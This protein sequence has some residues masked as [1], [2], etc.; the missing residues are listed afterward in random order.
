MGLFSSA[1]SVT[2]AGLHLRPPPPRRPSRS[3]LSSTAA[4]TFSRLR[5]LR[6]IIPGQVRRGGA[7]LRPPVESYLLQ[8]MIS[9]ALSRSGYCGRW[10]GTR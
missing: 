10:I 8:V 4:T 3:A 7:L 9:A 6:Q 5:F 2:N 1:R